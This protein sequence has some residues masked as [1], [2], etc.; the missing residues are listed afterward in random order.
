MKFVHTADTHLGYEITKIAQCHP[1]GRQKRAESISHNFMTIVQ[2]AVEIEADLFIH[3][4]DLF[5]K[6]YIPRETLDEI[7]RPILDLNRIGI[8]V[9]II[10]GNHERSEF[11]FD[12]FHGASNIFVFD[13]PKSLSLTLNG[14]SVGI[15]GFPFIRK[16]SKRTFLKALKETEY[17]DLRSDFNILVTHQA[18]DNATVGPVDFTFHAGRQDTVSRHTIPLDFDY[19]AAGHIH[20]YQILSHPLKPGLNFVYPGSIQRISFAEM[21]EEK[22]FVT[23]EILNN[24]IETRFN[25]LPV[26]DMEIVQIEAAGMSAEVCEND[27]R[28]QFW[29]FNEDM[30]IRFN[31]TGGTEASDYPDLDFQGLRHHM[32]PVL[33]CQFAI[34][35]GKRWIMR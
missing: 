32:P 3:S 17:E 4:G 33:E 26:C 21:N 19:I 24:R 8:A 27:I 31:L 18:F 20:R 34:K 22:G 23:G 13:R 30:V 29:R 2:E 10:P 15:A 35:A 28:S 1:Q 12:L 9:L 5:N 16:D 6:Y 25:P 11:P 14:Y 7:I